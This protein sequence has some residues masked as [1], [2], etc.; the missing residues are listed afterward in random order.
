MANKRRNLCLS[1]NLESDTQ[2]YEL[3]YY[4]MKKN[5]HSTTED[6][7]YNTIKENFEWK[8]YIPLGIIPFIS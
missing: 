7:L 4:H 5:E 2:S 8:N 1:T 3:R 6:V